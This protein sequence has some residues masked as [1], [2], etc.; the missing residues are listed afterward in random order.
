MSVRLLVG[1]AGTHE[2]IIRLLVLGLF[3][4][5]FS[6]QSISKVEEASLFCLF[7]SRNN[8]FLDLCFLVLCSRLNHTRRKRG[9]IMKSVVY[10][11]G[12]PEYLILLNYLGWG[13][14]LN[15]DPYKTG[16]RVLDQAYHNSV[17]AVKERLNSVN[18]LSGSHLLIIL[19]QDFFSTDGSTYSNSKTQRS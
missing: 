14:L 2:N 6:L 11:P 5:L 19:H 4:V 13:R 16:Q 9:R 7:F 12:F 10:T 15:R 18:S 17:S 3:V 1:W 8:I